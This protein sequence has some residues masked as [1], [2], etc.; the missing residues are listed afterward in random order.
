MIYKQK[1]EPKVI[2]KNVRGRWE[3]FQRFLKLRKIRIQKKYK[4]NIE[5]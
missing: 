2:E 3:N 5:I 4:L 1:K